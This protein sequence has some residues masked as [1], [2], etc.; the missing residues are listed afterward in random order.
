MIPKNTLKTL[1][2]VCIC[3]QSIASWAQNTTE[4]NDLAQVK[5]LNKVKA[6]L[7]GIGLEREQKLTKQATI[8]VGAA[9]ESVVPFRPSNTFGESDVLS[10]DYSINVSP[11]FYAG[12][13]NYYNLRNREKKGKTIAN[14]SA[15][16]FGMEY[17]LIAPILINHRYQTDD[18]SS[19]SPTWGFQKNASKHINLELI[20]GP[21]LQTNFKV[22]RLSAL[23]RFGINYLF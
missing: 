19:F 8:Y 23:A 4:T 11:V 12:F 5:S 18:V 20:L 6:Y 21:S 10:I 13:K 14:N 3:L 17:S 15:S 1:L 16:F 9:I 7:L 2:I 22:Y